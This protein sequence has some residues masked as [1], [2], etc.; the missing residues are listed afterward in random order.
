MFDSFLVDLALVLQYT[1]GSTV[2]SLGTGLPREAWTTKRNQLAVLADAQGWEEVAK[3]AR[4]A[5]QRPEAAP[6]ADAQRI[7]AAQQAAVARAGAAGQAG[8][9]AAAGYRGANRVGRPVMRPPPIDVEELLADAAAAVLTPA[10][11]PGPLQRQ[12][13]S[14]SDMSDASYEPVLPAACAVLSPA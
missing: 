5:M 11:G 7:L 2:S 14:T 6:A 13:S 1:S 12:A 3:A 4:A 9:G 8:A 10:G